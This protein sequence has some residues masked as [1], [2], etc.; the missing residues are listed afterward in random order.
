M[1]FSRKGFTQGMGCTAAGAALGGLGYHKLAPRF[2][3]RRQRPFESRRSGPTPS[4]EKIR[5]SLLFS[6]ILA[7]RKVP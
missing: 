4:A 1:R 2:Q 5:S 7:S 3:P 6:I